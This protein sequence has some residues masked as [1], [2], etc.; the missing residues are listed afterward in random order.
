M[1]QSKIKALVLCGIALTIFV[2]CKPNCNIVINLP[3]DLKPIDIDGYNDVH[4]VYWNYQ[5]DD[6]STCGFTGKKIKIYG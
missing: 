6:C 5:S 3:E 2:S 1:K 4:T